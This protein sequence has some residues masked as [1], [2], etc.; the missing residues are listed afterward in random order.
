MTTLKKIVT[1]HRPHVDERLA[2]WLLRLFGED[3]FPGAKSALVEFVDAGTIPVGKSADEREADGELWLGVG[4]GRFD[5]H[6]NGDTNR[7]HGECA[8]TLVATA[9][10]VRDKL[11]LRQLLD[12]VCQNDTAG[13]G[14]SVLN[15][16]RVITLMNQAGQEEDFIQRWAEASF[17]AFFQCQ[18]EFFGA[19]KDFRNPKVTSVD[20]I[21]LATRTGTKEIRLVVT[22]SANKQMASFARSKFGCGA[23]IVIQRSETSGHTFIS[24]YSGAGLRMEVLA[25]AIRQAELRRREETPL[26]EEEARREGTLARVPEW[27]FHRSGG[28]IMNGS[29]TAPNTV[30]SRLPLRRLQAIAFEAMKRMS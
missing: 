16:A 10:G 30:R 13:G 27:C 23:Q 12:A 18:R 21:R 7:V 11:E 24:C 9:L 28:W 2:I 22:S 14:G 6:P 4:G 15:V 8:A 1:H 25:A 29:L 20:E 26:S 19:E 3:Q 17:D 5:E